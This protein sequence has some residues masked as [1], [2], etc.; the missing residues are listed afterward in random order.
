MPQSSDELRQ[1]MMDYFGSAVDDQPPAEYL[2][3]QGFVQNPDWSWTAPDRIASGDQPISEQE[4]DCVV[5]LIEEWDMDGVT[6]LPALPA[7]EIG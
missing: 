1:K 6:N 7:E 5:F 4:R 2:R 3:Q